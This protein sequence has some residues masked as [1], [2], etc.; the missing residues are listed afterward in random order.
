LAA[1][2]TKK[3]RTGPRETRRSPRAE[4]SLGGRVG[5]RGERLQENRFAQPNTITL[6]FL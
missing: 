2:V 5:S 6:R 4:R 1:E 3:R